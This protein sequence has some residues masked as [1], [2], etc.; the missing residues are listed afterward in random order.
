[1]ATA[2]ATAL[3]NRLDEP[4][5]SL[6]SRVF[7]KLHGIINSSKDRRAKDKSES[8]NLSRNERLQ[9]GVFCFSPFCFSLS[10]C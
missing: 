2:E 5:S 7:N 3:H 8:H 1:M 10:V 6:T 9:V 4:R